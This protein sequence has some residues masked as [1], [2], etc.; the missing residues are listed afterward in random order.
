MQRGPQ[1]V[2][3]GQRYTCGGCPR[4]AKHSLLHVE[5]PLQCVVVLWGYQVSLLKTDAT[6]CFGLGR[7]QTSHSSLLLHP[8]SGSFQSEMLTRLTRRSGILLAVMDDAHRYARR[9]GGEG[10]EVDLSSGAVCLGQIST[11][12]LCGEEGLSLERRP[13]C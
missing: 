3:C 11:C 4:A 10:V 9:A 13:E 2:V 1:S 8:A 6:L 12:T 5:P 7:R